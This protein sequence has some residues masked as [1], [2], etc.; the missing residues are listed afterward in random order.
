MVGITYTTLTLHNIRNVSIVMSVFLSLLL[1]CVSSYNHPTLFFFCFVVMFNVVFLLTITL[2]CLCFALLCC[3]MS[4]FFL[5]SPFF[6]FVLLCCCL[7]S[8]FYLKSPYLV[9]L[10]LC[11]VVKCPVSSYNDPA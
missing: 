5:K 4:C 7:M 1:C 11:Y 2:I 10:L 6:A 3:L 9:F 8:C